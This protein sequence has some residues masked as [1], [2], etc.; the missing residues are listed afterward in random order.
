M[1][2]ASEKKPSDSLPLGYPTQPAALVDAFKS[3]KYSALE[4]VSAFFRL[5]MKDQYFNC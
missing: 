3:P 1:K 4:I 5:S 2:P